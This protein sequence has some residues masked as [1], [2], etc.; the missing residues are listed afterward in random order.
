MST[1]TTTTTNTTSTVTAAPL[2]AS[3]V[4]VTSISTLL[5]AQVKAAEK[6]A[7]AV[8][9]LQ[10]ESKANGLD[11]KGA[12]ALLANAYKGAFEKK[13]ITGPDLDAA[14]K[15]SAPD[16]SKMIR[17]AFPAD[18]TAAAE[19]AKVDAHN[20]TAKGLSVE[21]RFGNH[22]AALA[23]YGDECKLSAE[24]QMELITDFYADKAAKE[25]AQSASK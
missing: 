24:K 20:E 5:D 1:N 21:E 13:G 12:N 10:S 8:A 19:L 25:E 9:T 6:F 11:S 7:S 14:L 4:L 18:A 3:K 17:L 15:S 16:R 23:A 2:V 22:I